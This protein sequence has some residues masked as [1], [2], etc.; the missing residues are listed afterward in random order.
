M[1]SRIYCPN[2]SDSRASPHNAAI[3][4]WARRGETLWNGCE[5]RTEHGVANAQ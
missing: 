2:R 4:G 5:P 1:V 3:S